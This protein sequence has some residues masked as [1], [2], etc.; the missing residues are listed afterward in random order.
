MRRSEKEIRNAI[1]FHKSMEK[2]AEENGVK[3]WREFHRGEVEAL[4]WVLKEED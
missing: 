2:H 4:K 3:A 1:E